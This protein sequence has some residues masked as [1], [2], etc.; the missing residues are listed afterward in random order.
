MVSTLSTVPYIV[1]SVFRSYIGAP[2]PAGLG[3]WANANDTPTTS[4]AAPMIHRHLSDEV[5]GMLLPDLSCGSPMPRPRG[6]PSGPNVGHKSQA[7]DPRPST[8][9]LLPGTRRCLA[10]I[11]SQGQAPRRCRPRGRRRC[12]AES[13]ADGTEQLGVRQTAGACRKSG[14]TSPIL[15]LSQTHC[16]LSRAESGDPTEGV[17]AEDSPSDGKNSTVRR[18]RRRSRRL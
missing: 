13:G 8:L 14:H 18:I 11:R 1:V 7:S 10:R 4:S 9:L 2:C 12:Q 16:S 6:R 15:S 3:A 5:H 17:T